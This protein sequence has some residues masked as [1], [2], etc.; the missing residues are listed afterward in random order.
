MAKA[1]L[2]KAPDARRQDRRTQIASGPG[3]V[4]APPGITP[5]AEASTQARARTDNNKKTQMLMG[6]PQA[7]P[8][9]PRT[10][11]ADAALPSHQE[12]AIGPAPAPPVPAPDPRSTDAA[13][14]ADPD[15][16]STEPGGLPPPPGPPGMRA[17]GT[18]VTVPA[19][20]GRTAPP[21]AGKTHKRKKDPFDEMFGEDFGLPSK[22]TSAGDSSPVARHEY[23]AATRDTLISTK[24][25][26]IR[27]KIRDTVP[28]AQMRSG[29]TAPPVPGRDPL[30]VADTHPTF[31]T[32]PAAEPTNRRPTTSVIPSH[33]RDSRA[34]TQM[35][36]TEGLLAPA[37]DAPKI[38]LVP[39]RVIPGTRYLIKR[40]LGEGGMGVVYEV[41]HTDIERRSALKILRFDLSQQPQ[42]AQVFRD[43]ARAASRLGSPNI[44][45]VYDFG[46]LHDGR[47]YFA[48]ELL[49][50]QDLVPQDEETCME[51]GRFIGIMRQACKGLAKAHDAGVVHRDVKPENIILSEI[52]ERP[53]TVK[54]V[55]FGIS[56]M[57]AAGERRAGI[58][59]TP[60]YM[61]PEQILGDEFDGRLDIYALGCTAYEL[62]VGVPPFDADEVE[63]ILR[64]QLTKPPLPPSQV[65][66]GIV[67]PPAIEAVVM[68]C[69]AKKPQERYENM[70]DLEAALCEA[71]IEAGLVTPWDD[72]AVPMLADEARRER[73]V[74]RMPSP[75]AVIAPRSWV[76]PVVA[77]LSTLAAVGLAALLMFGGSPTDAERD[78]VEQLTLEAR[79]AASK[80]AWVVP[81]PNLDSKDTALLKVHELE[82]LDGSAEGLADDV[83]TDL[84][85]EFSGTLIGHGDKLWKKAPYISSQYYAWA[86]MFSDSEHAQ[87]RANI[88]MVTFAHFRRRLLAGEFNEAERLFAAAA[89]VAV[90]EDPE[91][92]AALKVA[93]SEGLDSDS[94]PLSTRQSIERSADEA[95]FEVPKAQRGA[96]VTPPPKKPPAPR[97]DPT[98]EDVDDGEL[99]V[100]PEEPVID[101]EEAKAEA[102]RKKRRRQVDFGLGEGSKEEFNPSRS[103]ELTKQ[104]DAAR[105]K[106]H[107][108]DASRLYGKAIAHN[109]HNGAAHYGLANVHFDLGNHHKASRSARNAVKYSPRSGDAHKLFGDILQREH[110]YQRALDAYKKAKRLGVDVDS[111]IADVKALLEK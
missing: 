43:E 14:V 63:D 32:N 105:K 78:K 45:E 73:I 8:S 17:S 89:G 39:G 66:E 12:T 97:E 91:Q 19:P 50:G 94:L 69:L 87:S 40:W 44:V 84:R 46:E 99:V 55:D 13:S 28:T 16:R 96:G 29:P 20:G 22:P 53:D 37:A 4:P 15:P 83:A 74:D 70:A 25:K 27:A 110:R 68:R 47:L 58:A 33:G 49:E 60:H 76:W 52:D 77:G 35:H 51:P 41:T 7:P 100:D 65:R 56:A 62:L 42:M 106:G 10:A 67:I 1:P 80:A 23:D 79:D 59:G 48:M 11:T 61:A 98:G 2:A 9:I 6:M 75:H 88:D 101:P 3:P 72:L 111:R 26:P 107:R 34:G 82:A 93:V 85:R 18:E 95:G 36:G 24:T 109:P 108:T 104:G 90:T 102:G 86:M 71:Q 38:R 103:T 92:A 31:E 5:A 30:D 57:L 81:P 54:I 64:Q 21:T